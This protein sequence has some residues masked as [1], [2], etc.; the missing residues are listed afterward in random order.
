MRI[1]LA[2]VESA[3]F[4]EEIFYELED[5]SQKKRKGLDF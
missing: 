5:L 3:N 1:L 2:K 4:L